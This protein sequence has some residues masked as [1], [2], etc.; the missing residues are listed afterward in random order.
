MGLYTRVEQIIVTLRPVFSREASF[1]W[2]VL[3]LWGVLL[4]TQPAA[5]TSYVNGIGLSEGYYHQAL[6][7][8][9]SSAFSIDGV[10]YRWGCWLRSHSH[11]HRLRGELVYVGDG[12][13][14]GKEGR[15]MPGVKALHQESEN[16]SK[17]TW[18]RG[19]YFSALGMLLG[20]GNVLFATPII[21]KLHD[22][23]PPV[24]GDASATLVEK[25][26]S[27]CVRHMA[28]GSYGLL[29]AYYASV[30][31]L[32]PFRENGIH[33]I[34]RA[35]ITT[36]AW[37]PFCPRPGKHGP[38]RPRQWG[39]KIK[40]NTL[41]A[42]IE[43]CLKTSVRLYGETV[44]VHYQEFQFH[45]DDPNELVLFVLTQ[46]P[47][48]KRIILL[49][50]DINLTGAEVIEAYG[51][52]FKIE[53]TFRTLV[54]LLDG[55][56]YQ[57]WL[58]LMDPASRWPETFEMAHYHWAERIKIRQK[59]EAFER[60]V[61]L[62]AIALGLL[63]ILSLEHPECIWTHFPRWFRTVPN[64]G[65]PTEQIVRIALQHL[66]AIVLSESRPALLLTKLLH[67]KT[68]RT[69]AFDLYDLV[70]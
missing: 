43:S 5:V 65:Y 17:P 38:G 26:A 1:E 50:S 32:K 7:W 2:F 58:K 21:L 31:V 34:S 23:I 30:K 54:H 36:V 22:G 19:H 14:V 13:K 44:T 48:G 28:K 15:K 68:E 51:W 52:R 29:D 33:L 39:S 9:H 8:F 24:E 62:N 63:Q 6:H 10:C 27:L 59:V 64:H 45:W 60:F 11:R 41:F 53:V 4:T 47:G 12:I 3:L 35:R 37:A 46:L 61:N 67:K 55:F 40:L 18:I 70:A 25:M 42:P 66:Q 57:F 16:V 69:K 56:A 20:T 49:S